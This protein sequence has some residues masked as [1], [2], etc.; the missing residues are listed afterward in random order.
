MIIQSPCKD[1][2][3]RCVYCHSNCFKYSEYKAEIAKQSAGVRKIK[4]AENNIRGF[5]IQ[6]VEACTKKSN[7]K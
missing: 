4:S 2:K 3:D 1:C 5:K 7:R 6:Q